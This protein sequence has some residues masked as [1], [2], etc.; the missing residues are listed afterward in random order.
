M[1]LLMGMIGKRGL[2]LLLGICCGVLLSVT[3]QASTIAVTSTFDTIDPTDGQCTLREAV[4]AANTQKASG[5]AAGECPAPKPNEQT[6]IQLAQTTYELTITG[7]FENAAAKGDLDILRNMTIQG[8][9]GG[10]A[11]ISAAKISERIFHLI[12]LPADGAPMI[13]SRLLLRNGGGPAEGAAIFVH[14]PANVYCFKSTFLNNTALAGGA[15]SSNDLATISI[16][17]SVFMGNT[18]SNGLGGAIFNLKGTVK[19]MRTSFN[20]NSA[21]KLG[22]GAIALTGGTVVISASSFMGNTSID[23]DPNDAVVLGKSGGAMQISGGELYLVNSTLYNNEAKESG[24]ALHVR[25]TGNKTYIWN[26]TIHQNKAGSGGGI[27]NSAGGEVTLANSIL[28]GNIAATAPECTG[29]F[30]SMGHNLFG[31]GAVTDCPGLQGTLQATDIQT[32]NP[33]LDPFVYGVQDFPGTGHFP[34]AY[35]SPAINKGDP[36]ACTGAVVIGGQTFSLLQDQVGQFRIGAC[37]IGAI[38]AQAFCG[39][40]VVQQNLGETC[41]CAAD[42]GAD[43]SLKCDIKTCQ[44][45]PAVCGDGVVQFGEICDTADPATKKGCNACQTLAICGNGVK[46]TDEVCDGEPN[47]NAC[48][49]F[50]VCG[51]GKVTAGEVCDG[52]ANCNGCVSF[53]LCQNAIK[54]AGEAC[55]GEST[56]NDCQFLSVC[57]DGKVTAG[58]VCD[59]ADPA[60]KQGCAANCGSVALCGDGVV[61]ADEACDTADPQTQAGCNPDCQSKAVCGDGKVTAGEV[62]DGTQGCSADCHALCGN[63]VIEGQEVCDGGAGCFGG[64]LAKAV[65]GND[66]VEPGEACDT[67]PANNDLLPNACRTNC[68][69]AGCGDLVIDAGEKCDDGNTKNG[70]GCAGN[71]A[72]IEQ[73]GDGILDAGEACDEGKD[74]ATCAQCRLPSCGDGILTEG[75]QCDT[76]IANSD[77][78][79]DACRTTCKKAA[80]GDGVLDPKRGEGCDDGNT[81]AEDG[82]GQACQAEAS[83]PPPP[84]A[85]P[86]PPGGETVAPGGEPVKPVPSGGSQT[87]NGSKPADGD[88]N[89]ADNGGNGGCSLIIEGA[90]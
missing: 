42:C 89:N 57:G 18:A 1:V 85:P 48:E 38:E 40:G 58:E 72:K 9:P 43:W 41:D 73:C 47:C 80:C 6:I 8:P 67:G 3:A 74:S 35:A 10:I 53:S 88:A 25:N 68:Q 4:I 19:I 20:G 37:D 7:N 15:I 66:I 83:S 12:N 13:L 76:G 81:V 24:G 11:V 84:I 32:E 86:P 64:C 71:C 29:G 70:D 36:E 52:E 63:G 21:P 54:E 56:C 46:E 44:A 61:E 31:A 17:D 5:A 77:S 49:S 27:G 75:E 60:T 50:S 16:A 2:A 62:C 65:C 69:T 34:L 28:A 90:R 39:D 79:P 78:V 45:F 22:G 51:D 23:P 33:R 82:C 26:S 14:G 87:T 59:T 30:T 55:D